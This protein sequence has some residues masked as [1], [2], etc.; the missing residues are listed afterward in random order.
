LIGLTARVLILLAVIL[1]IVEGLTEFLPISS[2]GHLIIADKWLAFEA[3]MGGKERSDAFLVFIQLG[4]ILAVV[5]NFRE[6]MWEHV[7]AAMGGSGSAR[8]RRFLA[9]IL[10]ATA[11]AVAA[12]LLAGQYLDKLPSEQFVAWVLIVG[13]V[14]LWA[15]EQWRPKVRFAEAEDFGWG[16][17]LLIGCAQTLAMLFPGLSRSGATIMAAL[18][19][20]ASNKAAAEFSFFLSI[21]TM[22]LACVYKLLKAVREGYVAADDGMMWGVFGVGFVVAFVSALLVVR[23][24]L[25]FLRKHGFKLFAYYRVVLG[26]VV[27]AVARFS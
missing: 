20:G 24:F 13:G 6:R 14:A 4:A 7:G 2:T 1:G 3:A 10:V 17:I 25:A 22:F 26:V 9:G 8:A 23:A 16:V 21:P 12:G 5:W 15:V 18:V 11:P 19:L 27:L